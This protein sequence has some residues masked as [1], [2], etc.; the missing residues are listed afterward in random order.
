MLAFYYP[1]ANK[2]KTLEGHHEA[3]HAVYEHWRRAWALF[4][5]QR[6]ADFTVLSVSLHKLCSTSFQRAKGESPPTGSYCCPRQPPQ[7]HA[8]I[9]DS[10]VRQEIQKSWSRDP[11]GI[12]FLCQSVALGSLGAHGRE[13]GIE[14]KARDLLGEEGVTKILVCILE[15]KCY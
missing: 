14:R 1:K 3:C 5:S 12:L 13:R 6:G 9:P 7:G 4:S 15:G 8:A 10:A 2:P 11:K